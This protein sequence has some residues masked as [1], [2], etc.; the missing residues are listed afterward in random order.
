LTGVKPSPQQP[1]T[2]QKAALTVIS[3][4]F[5]MTTERTIYNLFGTN[6]QA[7]VQ[8]AKSKNEVCFEAKRK[9]GAAPLYNRSEP[10]FL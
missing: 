6:E 2:D 10:R 4:L 8:V 3:F 1:F 7:S 5:I 9:A